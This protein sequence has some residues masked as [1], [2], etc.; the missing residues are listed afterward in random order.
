MNKPQRPGAAMTGSFAKNP[1]E[2]IFAYRSFWPQPGTIR[3]MAKIGIDTV[4]FFPAN[5]VCSLGIPYSEY[6]PIWIGPGTYD[7]SPFDQQ[8]RM[9]IKSNP[10]IKLICMVDLNT[11]LWWSRINGF[12][13]DSFHG[14]GKVASDPDWRKD[15]ADYLQRTLEH[16]ESNYGK[17]IAAYVLAAGGTCEWS[18][19]SCGEES[20]SRRAAYRRW[21]LRR[22]QPDPVDIPSA[23]AREHF[24]H[25]FLR[26]PAI[27]QPAL[28]YARFCQWQMSDAILHFANL[29]RKIIARKKS[30]GVFFGYIL[31]LTPKRL[32][33]IGHVDYERVFRSKNLDFFI[34][35]APYSDGQIGEASGFILPI[36]TLSCLKKRFIQEI[37][38]RTH[39]A[40]RAPARASGLAPDVK[41]FWP[42]EE[43][44][45]AGL[46]R[47]F[48]ICLIEGISLW[49]FDMWGRWYE[50]KRVRQL[51]A[52]MKNIWEKHGHQTMD[53]VGE[54]AL[55]VDPESVLHMSEDHHAS[56][57]N[58]RCLLGRIG[59]PFRIHSFGDLKIIN[60]D[61]F[62]LMVFPNLYVVNDAKHENLRR[63]LN[64]NRHILWY[65]KPG[66]VRNERYA[67]DH[68]R[69]LTGITPTKERMVSK[70]MGAWT[71]ILSR[72]PISTVDGMR[73][74]A[75]KAG[76][77]CYS[78]SGEPIYANERFLAIHSAR[79]GVRKF[80]LPKKY[81]R[82]CNVF[83]HG[84]IAENTSVFKDHL[85]AP[86]T[87]IYELVE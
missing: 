54:I 85:R 60:P 49:W 14:L 73:N 75:A 22:G 23:S 62:K 36:H 50:G 64:N 7:F 78:D 33:H 9:L 4:C 30:L 17:H 81:S 52:Q 2:K 63:F 15:T 5:V 66:I 67:E 43:A 71:S 28:Q 87:I 39:T 51:L 59:A 44:T 80:Q 8:A 41:E 34:A 65:G 25:G 42:N 70:N 61:H 46:K 86:D 1:F 21:C 82:I 32:M 6:P 57:R 10:N 19:H 55:V 69:Q 29:S 31:E 48:A 72:V 37:D 11:P 26:D 68:V 74:I 58:T 53:P 35:T 83:T 13:H 16:A 40:N 76:V 47:E 3:Q 24:T 45:L 20:V 84:I 38:H 77:H 56:I 18:D 12:R 27:D 79:G